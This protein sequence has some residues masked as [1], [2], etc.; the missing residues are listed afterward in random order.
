LQ[1]KEILNW[2]L[3]WDPQAN[4]LMMKTARVLHFV[5]TEIYN[6]L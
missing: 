3:K 2:F 1:F 6:W 5:Y 4:A